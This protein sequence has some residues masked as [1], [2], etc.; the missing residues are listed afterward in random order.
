[1]EKIL[2]VQDLRVYYDLPQGTVKAVD[3]VSFEVYDGEIFGIAGESGSGKST[4]ALAIPRLLRPPAK[5]VSGKILF[6]GKDLLTLDD[7]DLRKMRGREISMIF[8]DPNTYL[9]PVY[10]T[11][12]QVAEVYEAHRGGAFKKYLGEVVKL[13]KIVKIADP[14]RRVFT[15]P[16]QMS[17]GM[18]QRVL[19]SMAIAERPRLIIADEPTSALDVTIQAEIMDLLNEIKKEIRSSIIFITH[20]LSLLLEIADRIMIMYAGKV[21]EI[22]RADEIAK[23]PMHP[24]T[25]ALLATLRYERKKRLYTIPGSLPS[26]IKP[27]SGCRFHPRCL[28]AKDVCREKEPQI[29]NINGRWVSCILYGDEYEPGSQS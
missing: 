18:K 27:P 4:L 26:L 23:D 9:N 5:I 24:Y 29:L 13:F 2:E 19:I 7:K 17:G 14:E 12:Y 21:V 3:G 6:M 20:D 10:F 1:M 28:F 11:G 25:K 8:Q 22:G 16:H 15:Y